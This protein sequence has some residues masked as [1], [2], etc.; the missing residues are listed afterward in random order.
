MLLAVVILAAFPT[1][2]APKIKK[3]KVASTDFVASG[4]IA[5]Q[6][7]CSD[8]G[9]FDLSP[10]L[11]WGKGP[12]RTKSY[13]VTVYDPDAEFYHW[14]IYN[15]PPSILAL[16][17]ATL[18]QSPFKQTLNDFGA[19]SYGGPCPPV[20][21]QHRYIFT[22]YALSK[23]ISLPRN[24]DVTSLKRATNNKILA[25]GTL[26][27]IFL[28][29]LPPTLVP[30][31][32]PTQIPTST[33]TQIPT[34]TPTS[35]SNNTS[36][37]TATALPTVTSTQTNT[38]TQTPTITPTP[39]R[40]PTHTPTATATN[41]PTFT[42]TNTPTAT[43][44]NT[45]TITPTPTI[46]QTATNTATATSTHTPTSTPTNTPT[47]TSTAT[48][49]ST[50][51]PLSGVN[52]ISVGM[53]HSCAIVSGGV[54]CWGLNDRG[55]LGN[56]P[57]TPLS[58]VD[59][60]GLSSGATQVSAGLD[61]TCALTSGGGVKCW[62]GGFFGQLGNNGNTASSVPVDVTGLSTGVT[63][64]SVYSQVSCALTSVG[65]VKCWGDFN[66]NGI[67]FRVPTDISSLGSEVIQVSVGCDHICAL[68]TGGGVKCRGG[69]S[70]GQLGNG[71]TTSNY[72]YVNVSGL[73]SGVTQIA[74]GCG[75]TC[76]VTTGGGVKCW[77]YNGEGQVGDNSTTTRVTPVDV[78]GL[79]S[80]FVQVTS[81]GIHACALNTDGGLKCWGRNILGGVGDTTGT[82]R[83]T[84]V[85]VSGLT[86][87][88]AAIDAKSYQT[89][90][91]TTSNG[92][93]CW[94]NNTYG[95][96]GDGSTSTRLAPVDVRS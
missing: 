70:Y 85:D 60:T 17:Q 46:T 89:C 59:V 20:G 83:L 10:Q 79:S 53:G 87:G 14:G 33:R 66:N 50:P 93:K 3:L 47:A 86:S 51:L 1:Y 90:A 84:P 71:S 91:V 76:A 19:A 64:I 25:K 63:Q 5:S 69:N 68:A 55:Q 74:T 54:K 32:R 77:G 21:Q 18:A 15:I 31:Q 23:K 30:T 42:P 37:P 72:N 22:V 29:E 75:S 78:S 81:S 4:I 7:A 2:A 67:V 28:G 82:T 65:G 26:T 36:I 88:A 8:F 9:G 34:A 96:L 24:A 27:G 95:Q 13:A 52:S 62:G 92:A 58:R 41:A 12:K 44:T 40:T 48:P 56:T 73:S 49:T 80:G 45:A 38:P 16:P 43:A 57:T 6:F 39:T 35:Q 11:S 61:H 94:G